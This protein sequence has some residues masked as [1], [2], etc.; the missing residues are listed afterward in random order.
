MS[1]QYHRTLAVSPIVLHRFISLKGTLRYQVSSGPQDVMNDFLSHFNW[2]LHC[3]L[4]YREYKIFGGAAS[5]RFLMQFQSDIP[6]IPIQRN[7]GGSKLLNVS[8]I[9]QRLENRITAKMI[10]KS[11]HVNFESCRSE[12]GS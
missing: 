9:G 12:I 2:R 5:N 4:N 3:Y 8:A 10:T 1:W 7:A 6:G 11:L